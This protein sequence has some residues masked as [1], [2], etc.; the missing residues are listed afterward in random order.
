MR[1][2]ENSDLQTRHVPG[3]ACHS[4]A[5]PSSQTSACCALR[6]MLIKPSKAEFCAL[7]GCLSCHD[8][9]VCH[10]SDPVAHINDSGGRPNTYS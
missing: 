7:H 2:L 9:L 3:L 5:A 6:R 8:D 1:R 4:I 10:I